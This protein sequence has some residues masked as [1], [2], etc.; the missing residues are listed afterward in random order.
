MILLA[1][2]ILS[3][4]TACG[5]PDNG[6]STASIGKKMSY[7]FEFQDDSTDFIREGTDLSLYLK[8]R[9]EYDSLLRTRYS[10]K[11]GLAASPE[12]TE[13]QRSEMSSTNGKLQ[14][15]R[16]SKSFIKN[17]K[18]FDGLYDSYAE[19]DIQKNNKTIL[20]KKFTKHDF[21]EKEDD[22]ISNAILFDFSY[23]MYWNSKNRYEFSVKIVVPKS[24]ETKSYSLYIN[25]DGVC[26]VVEAE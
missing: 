18:T 22:F 16:Y 10:S 11:K 17:G 12:Y 20:Q 19:V 7:R 9:N 14:Y 6:K 2:S 3:I 13:Y 8:H 25:D 15:V 23:L 5:K 26:E 1:F 4:P 21:Y 24:G